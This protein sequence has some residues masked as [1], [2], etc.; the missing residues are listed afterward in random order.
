MTNTLLGDTLDIHV[1][2]ED[3]VFPH[4]ENEIAQSESLTG[5]PFVHYWLHVRHLLINGRKMSKS[6]G[7]YISFDKVLTQYDVN[8]LRYFFLSVH[9]RRPIDF[10]HATMKIAQNSMTRLQTT[11]DLIDDAL[12]KNEGE[13][14]VPI[15]TFTF[16]DAIHQYRRAFEHSMDD[17]LDTHSALDALHAIS[18]TINEYCAAKPNRAAL[19]SARHVYRQLLDAVGFYSIDRQTAPEQVPDHSHALIN[20]LLSLRNRLRVDKN[21]ILS[22]YIRDELT[23]LGVL[24]TDTP[25]ETTWKLK[26]SD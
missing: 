16:L 18:K 26:T 3:L 11:F 8:T 4:H 14:G 15:E 13:L 9:Y 23:Q 1:G 5:K 24:L 20:L 25:N 17:D 21:Y 19:T 10:T 2:G 7:N 22:D 12:A 6:L